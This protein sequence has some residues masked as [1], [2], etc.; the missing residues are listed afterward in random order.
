MGD[1]L[2]RRGSRSR[3]NPPPTPAPRSTRCSASPRTNGCVRSSGGQRVH[4]HDRDRVDAEVDRC[5]DSGVPLNVEY[6]YLAKDGGVVWVWD[7]A[8]L[9]SRDERGRP[10][11][12]QGVMLDITARKEAETKAA[13]AE[14]WFK[15]LT[16]QNPG[17]MSVVC[18]RDPDPGV[19]WRHSYVSPRSIEQVRVSAGGILRIARS[20]VRLPAPRRPGPGGRRNRDHVENR[21]TVD[22]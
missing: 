6:R 4:P 2:A 15:R 7:R 21:R 13:E 10:R 14:A 9:R 8:T 5:I 19:R 3:K 22:Q 17:I 11:L 20:M 16:E 1:E 12:F 18:D